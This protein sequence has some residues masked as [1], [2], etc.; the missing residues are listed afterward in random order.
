[1]KTRDFWRGTSGIYEIVNTLTG[2]RYYGSA[3]CLDRRWK[4]H[5]CDLRR[6]RH[7]NSFLQNAWN[8]YGED[9]FTFRVLVVLEP[10]QLRSHEQRLLDRVHGKNCYNIALDASVPMTGRKHRP[11][12]IAKQ[13]ASRIAGGIAITWGD[14]I[15]AARRR[16]GTSEAQ[17]KVHAAR[18]GIS[19]SPDS[20]AKMAAASKSW[21]ANATP[22]E[23]AARVAGIRTATR[24]GCKH[25]AETKAKMSATRMGRK[26]SPETRAKMSAAKRGT[27]KTPEMCAAMSAARMGRPGRPQGEA[28]REIKRQKMHA[29]W[30]AKKAAK[31]AA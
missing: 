20:I 26:M 14:K 16:T 7:R 24:K 27:K 1:V 6:N 25:S 8:K 31:Q 28:E 17:R 9:A 18:R 12:S 2:A 21:W 30:A 19:P 13:K 4:G 29:Y 15:S 23:K 5:V 3:R 22:E 10:D 11:E